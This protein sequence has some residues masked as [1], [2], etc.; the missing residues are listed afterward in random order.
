VERLRGDEVQ[1][2]RGGQIFYPPEDPHGIEERLRKIAGATERSQR[3][4]R[5]QEFIDEVI[6]GPKPMRG[7]SEATKV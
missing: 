3:R 6:S 7:G 2:R 5:V 1:R 4:V